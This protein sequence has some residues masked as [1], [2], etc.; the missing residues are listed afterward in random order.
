LPRSQSRRTLSAV[1][2]VVIV[3]LVNHRLLSTFARWHLMV[4]AIARGSLEAPVER[5]EAQVDG[6]SLDDG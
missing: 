6:M 1:D 4:P 2:E 3:L 5:V